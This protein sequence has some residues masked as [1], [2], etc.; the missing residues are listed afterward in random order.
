[1]KRMTIPFLAALAILALLTLSR[2]ARSSGE[3]N[4]PAVAI[5]GS[6]CFAVDAGIGNT[7]RDD[8]FRWAQ[9]VDSTKL[10]N[11]LA[12]KIGIVF[13]CS[14][15]SGDQV[16]KGFGQMSGIIGDYVSNPACFNN[17]EAVTGRDRSAHERWA[18]SRTREQ[19]RDNLQWKAVAAMKCLNRDNQVAFFADESAVLAHIP[20]S[21]G[22]GEGGGTG[23]SGQYLGCYK[24]TDYRDVGD[25]SQGGYYWQDGNGMTTERC[26]ASCSGKGYAFAATQASSYCFCGNSYGKYGKADNCNVKCSG[27]SGQTCGGNYANSVYRAK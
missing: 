15:V 3:T 19:V 13:N 4:T 22:G 24:D 5:Q 11:N 7:N 14:S 25:T 10:M 2:P 21:D 18:R 9:Q 17:D 16:A 12:W 8:H 1:M 6:P 20:S 23:S 27:S 26:I